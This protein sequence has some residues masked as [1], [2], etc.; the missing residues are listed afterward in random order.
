M[1]SPMRAAGKDD[2]RLFTRG[3]QPR[4]CRPVALPPVLL[5]HHSF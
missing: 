3:F 5:F 1:V 4:T 2:L